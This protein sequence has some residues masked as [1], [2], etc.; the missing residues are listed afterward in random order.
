M[1]SPPP[2]PKCL[3]STRQ[4]SQ[5]QQALR[6][7]MPGAVPRTQWLRWDSNP[8]RA[9]SPQT[10]PS[11]QGPTSPSSFK[12]KTPTNKG[13]LR[14][15]CRQNSFRSRALRPPGI[16]RCP[17]RCGHSGWTQGQCHLR[18]SGGWLCPLQVSV[19]PS[20][21]PTPVAS[22]H[23][24]ITPELLSPPESSGLPLSSLLICVPT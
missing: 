14:K 22:S 20:N 24:E 5:H 18:Q 15:C 13:M 9:G 2:P 16:C 11:V 23:P 6:S 8:G 10:T 3:L 12:P 21:F 1:A 4:C 7:G 17:H 19:A